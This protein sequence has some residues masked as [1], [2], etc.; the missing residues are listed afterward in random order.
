MIDNALALEFPISTAE[1]VVKLLN[2]LE[3]LKEKA[4]D[5]ISPTSYDNIISLDY[6]AKNELLLIEYEHYSSGYTEI[7]DKRVPISW[8][9]LSDKE[10]EKAKEEV[11]RI[12]FAKQ[13]EKER[14]A[15]EARQKI[16]EAEERKEYLRL[17]KKFENDNKNAE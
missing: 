2:T 9:F 13:L 12:E 10:L 8:L 14:K 11:R 3:H 6:D 5:L 15:L 17:K 1:D 4:G 16:I 7:D